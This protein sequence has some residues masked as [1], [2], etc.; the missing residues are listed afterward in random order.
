MSEKEQSICHRHIYIMGFARI[1]WLG[2]LSKIDESDGSAKI[3]VFWI[4]IEDDITSSDFDKCLPKLG[5]EIQYVDL[6]IGYLTLLHINAIL[7]R[8]QIV[9]PW[10]DGK[11]PFERRTV[12]P[13]KIN[14]CREN[15]TPFNRRDIDDLE[16]EIISFKSNRLHNENEADSKCLGIR[17]GDDPY[18]IIFSCAE[19]MRFFYCTSSTMANTLF[20]GRINSPNIHIFDDSDGKSFGPLD[21]HVFVTL[22][23]DMLDSDARII[24][25]LFSN[26]EALRNAQSLSLEAAKD[27]GEYRDIISYP[28]FDDEVKLEFF[29]IPFEQDGKKRKFV[30]RIIKSHHHPHF[31]TLEFDRENNA[32]NPSEDNSDTKKE[33]PIENEEGDPNENDPPT[34]EDG[35]FI[36]P[37]IAA[38]IR[39]AELGSRFP[40]LSRIP[41]MKIPPSKADPKGRK[42]RLKEVA[43]TFQGW[44][45]A[46][47]NG[48]GQKLRKVNIQSTDSFDQ[49]TTESK[50]VELDTGEVEYRRTIKLL[51]IAN[52]KN[53]AKIEYLHKVLPHYVICD[54][55]YFNVYPAASKDYFPRQSFHL[56][57]KEKKLARMVLIAQ[58]KKGDRIRYLVDI[59]QKMA[60]ELSY[61]VFWFSGEQAPKDVIL[62]LKE[63]LYAYAATK[64]L[65]GGARVKVI[66]LFWG[67]FK[68]IQNDDENWIVDQ[69]FNLKNCK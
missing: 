39:R 15:I 6:P 26:P 54:G 34:L 10:T 67:S 11:L 30:T 19:I 38:T 23:K 25:D 36:E 31:D 52:E 62:K 32:E 3:K 7:H 65:S 56:I 8:G 46:Q 13:T 22:R 45:T 40:E 18:A 33:F 63:A 29:F 12:E 55:I 51:Q 43:T 27:K 50:H 68:H 57:N 9:N 16:K 37:Q 21:G 20:D 35:T 14:F 17:V 60:K 69:V 58:F 28:P 49:A 5:A 24:A 53:L 61:Q 48:K 42:R 41:C 64:T 66:G 44:T 2:K 4:E 59:Q 1:L 47:G